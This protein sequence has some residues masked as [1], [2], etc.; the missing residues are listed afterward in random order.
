MY[1]DIIGDIH[2]HAGELKDLLNKLGY[3]KNADGI[4]SRQGHQAIF[5]GDFIDRG[6][7][8]LAVLR[9][10]MP[11]VEQGHALAVM[12]NHEYNAICFHTKHP[13]TG[14]P[15]RAHSEKN[16]G[17]H[18]TFL[19]EF[20]GEKELLS[21]VI[22]WF[23]TLPLFL[24]LDGLR[25]VH[26]EWNFALIQR[27]KNLSGDHKKFLLDEEFLLNS[28]IEGSVEHKI[29]ETLLKGSEIDL[30]EGYHFEDKDGTARDAVRI[31]WW[32]ASGDTF[33]DVAMLN[34]DQ[35]HKIPVWP[36]PPNS[37]IPYP[38]NEK[39]VFFGHYWMQPPVTILAQNAVCVDYGLA[40]GGVLCGYKW[41]G[42]SF[43][44]SEQF[45]FVDRQR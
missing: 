9:T 32:Q 43:L 37:I 39:P 25:I 23:K 13:E 34:D 11:M 5:A 27:L 26:A 7:Q 44:Q 38:A 2:G 17:Q 36:F 14:V 28:T 18:K 15:L 35:I 3:Q 1:Y 8:N 20:G 16:I 4:F 12:G 22:D 21:E 45:L 40:K 33:R 19:A 29:V 30:P 42:E 31:K 24:D 10:V 6:T 41:G